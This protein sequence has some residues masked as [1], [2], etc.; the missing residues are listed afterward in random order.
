MQSV[1]Y[2]TGG[3]I[4]KPM[5]ARVGAQEEISQETARQ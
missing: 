1:E 3:G 2:F 5:P 4:F